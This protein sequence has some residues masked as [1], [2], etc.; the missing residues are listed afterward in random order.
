MRPTL[1][2]L[3]L[4]ALLVAAHGRIAAANELDAAVEAPTLLIHDA[5]ETLRRY[6]APDSVGRL[7]LTLPGGARYELVTTTSDPAI[8]NPGDGAF[9]P[10]DE[11]VVREALAGVRYP[12]AGLR[13]EVFLLPYPRREGLESAAGPGLV[14]LSPGVRPLSRERQHAEFVHELGHV[15]HHA[16]LADSDAQGWGSYRT[17]RAIQDPDRY[18]QTAAHAYRPHEIFAEDF[19]ALFGDALA[20]Y[21]GTIENAALAP[22]ASVSGLRDFMLALAGVTPAQALQ[23]AP[24]PARGAVEFSAALGHAAP[25]DLFDAQ[26][27]RVATLEPTAGSGSTRWSWNGRGAGGRPAHGVL[28]ARVRGSATPATRVTLLR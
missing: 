21:S 1:R 27:R 9:H 23:A 2:A 19:R 17:L 12:V 26:G 24:N 28:Y 11:S 20:N 3:A 7:W 8:L 6:C 14:L 15:V 5:D 22:P 4:A 16:L 13:A 18:S 10:F 25:L